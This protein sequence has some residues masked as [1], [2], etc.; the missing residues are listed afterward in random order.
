MKI[1]YE[2]I[3]THYSNS[4]E[5]CKFRIINKNFCCKEIE[6]ALESAYLYI[7]DEHRLWSRWGSSLYHIICAVMYHSPWGEGDP[8]YMQI[9]YCPFCSQK[10]EFLSC[11]KRIYIVK[12]EILTKEYKEKEVTEEEFK[13]YKITM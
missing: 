6:E 7:G 1:T 4:N 12:E 2:K 8:D 11:I 9:N 3:I 5:R 13:E 10:I